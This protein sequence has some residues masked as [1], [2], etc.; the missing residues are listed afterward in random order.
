M[1]E[2]GKRYQKS[3]CYQTEK[4][5]LIIKAQG[6]VPRMLTKARVRRGGLPSRRTFQQHSIDTDRHYG[7]T[8]QG[9]VLKYLKG[10]LLPLH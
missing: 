4:S 2:E 8:G 6:V 9:G 3:P 5:V 1:S 10:K 7:N